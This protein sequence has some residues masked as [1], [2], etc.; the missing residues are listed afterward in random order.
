MPEGSIR[1]IQ[2]SV[3]YSL[4]KHENFRILKFVLYNS[5]RK[6]SFH[7]N[8]GIKH[9]G[10]LKFCVWYLHLNQIL[11]QNN[12]YNFYNWEM[13]FFQAK[14]NS[15]FYWGQ[16][17]LWQVTFKL[18]CKSDINL[19]MN[20]WGFSL[21]LSI[22]LKNISLTTIRYSLIKTCIPNIVT[23]YLLNMIPWIVLA[24]NTC[25]ILTCFH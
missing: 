20:Y 4:V 13:N 5:I 18:S 9:T 1:A 17:S 8:E 24:K 6:A 15:A 3:S 23:E 21:W 12:N 16:N 22:L 7:L 19:H 10:F 14:S 11:S 25:N 2:N